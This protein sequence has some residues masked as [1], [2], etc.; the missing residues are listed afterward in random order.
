MNK[1]TLFAINST[2]KITIICKIKYLLQRKIPLNK[3]N[4]KKSNNNLKIKK[5]FFK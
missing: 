3:T 4:S 5:S 1:F 2:H